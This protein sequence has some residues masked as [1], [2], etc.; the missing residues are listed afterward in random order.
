[1]NQT[2]EATKAGIDPK[3][4]T[5]EQILMLREFVRSVGGIERAKTAVEELSKGQK[6]A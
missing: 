3:S 1:M 4:L 2:Q 5:A 6:A